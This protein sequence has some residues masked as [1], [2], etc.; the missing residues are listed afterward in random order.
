MLCRRISR[1]SHTGDTVLL[2]SP[3]SHSE[4]VWSSELSCSGYAVSSVLKRSTCTVLCEFLL[5]CSGNAVSSEF[6]LSHS[7]LAVSSEF[8]CPVLGILC[9]QISRCHILGMLCRLGLESLE[10]K[11]ER[12]S[13]KLSCSSHMQDF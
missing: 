4:Y 1:L 6:P 9:R 12:L 8:R 7:Q 10:R 13:P 11:H 3:L 2:K 5:T